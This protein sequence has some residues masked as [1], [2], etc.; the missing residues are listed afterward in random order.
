MRRE[1]AWFY[2][3][4]EASWKNVLYQKDILSHLMKVRSFLHYRRASEH[5]VPVNFLTSCELKFNSQCIHSCLLL[6][7]AFDTF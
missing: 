4:K 6:T 2:N 5:F 3:W 1:I 7:T